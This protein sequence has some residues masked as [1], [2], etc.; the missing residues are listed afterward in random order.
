MSDKYIDNVKLH[1]QEGE[2]FKTTH[3]NLW[4]DEYDDLLDE[5]NEIVNLSS[6][7]PSA[8]R[9]MF[10]SMTI[11]Q[12][13]SFG[14]YLKSIDERIDDKIKIQQREVKKKSKKICWN[15][16]CSNFT[17]MNDVYVC[18]NC[19]TELELKKK[20]T[21]FTSKELVDFTKHINK[22]LNMIM[23]VVTMSHNM[24]VIFPYI[25]EWFLK[26][27]L[28]YS[29]LKFNDSVKTFI[30]RYNKSVNNPIDMTFFEHEIDRDPNNIIEYMGFK[31]ICD[32]FY[33]LTQYVLKYRLLTS[34]IT[35]NDNLDFKV[36]LF[37]EYFNKYNNGVPTIP[38]VVDTIEYDNKI[39]EIGKYSAF[40]LVSNVDNEFKDY[41]KEH[42]NI[43]LKLPGMNFDY[44]E[45]Y[46]KKGTFPKKFVYQQNYI[47]IIYRIYNIPSY[48]INCKDKELMIN[49]I[50][51]FN[52][53][54]KERKKKDSNSKS[55]SCLWE[56]SLTCILKLPYFNQYKDIIKILPKKIM[57]TNMLITENWFLYR[58]IKHDEL[59]KFNRVYE[60]VEDEEII[61]KVENVDENVD[62][63]KLKNF[64]N[65]VGQDY[66]SDI[67]EEYIREK[68]NFQG[69]NQDWFDKYHL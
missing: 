33:K 63:K 29:W 5:L 16:G 62:K 49:L 6:L 8:A 10:H 13:N 60:K 32:E 40:L 45:L 9:N 1:I 2:K 30:T 36:K 37:E 35:I 44:N 65:G 54:N 55:N 18:R 17:I 50:I 7:D 39:Y 58:L 19:L 47:P 26:R 31:L 48:N 69:L 23:G 22:Q 24:K 56:V 59:E 27:E 43:S 61:K 67:S 3:P 11:S 4:K 41:M 21:Q 53:F 57:S 52:N 64:I 42:Y 66:G 12:F 20:N 68:N 34:N 25:V 38:K 15:C 46:Y 51:D 28:M 14:N